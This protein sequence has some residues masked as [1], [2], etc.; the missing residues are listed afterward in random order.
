MGCRPSDLNPFIISEL[1]KTFSQSI[2]LY[3][4]EVL[5]YSSIAINEVN[6]RQ[7]ILIK[8]T[9][10]LSKF[11]RSTPLFTALRIKTFNHLL[12][13]HKLSYIT[14]LCKVDFTKKIYENLNEYYNYHHKPT[15]SFVKSLAKIREN[16]DIGDNERRKTIINK[17]L[18]VYFNFLNDGY[19]LIDSVKPILRRIEKYVNNQECIILLSSLL[20]VTPT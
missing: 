19:G 8:N 11:V 20:A 5:N 9:I 3:G 13:E 17:K 15:D 10:G 18:D 2:L 7:N 6:I 14:Q 4:F 12:W 16:L 1:Y